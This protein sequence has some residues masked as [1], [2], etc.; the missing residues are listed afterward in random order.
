MLVRVYSAHAFLPYLC[1]IK[2]FNM[3]CYI[4]RSL[5]YLAKTSTEITI[6]ICSAESTR[7]ARLA[8]YVRKNVMYRWNKHRHSWPG[9]DNSKLRLYPVEVLESESQET[10][11]KQTLQ[12][13]SSAVN[14]PY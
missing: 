2:Y 11:E 12:L 6:Y 3:Y 4:T 1:A 10:K 8:S 7:E 5:T 13:S 14:K 9:W